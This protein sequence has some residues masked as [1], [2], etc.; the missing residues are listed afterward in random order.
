MVNHKSIQVTYL[1][2]LKKIVPPA[3]F[4]YTVQKSA[5]IISSDAKDTRS[6][7]DMQYLE[8]LIFGNISHIKKKKFDFPSFF[9]FLKTKYIF[10]LKVFSFEAISFTSLGTM[11]NVPSFPATIS[12]VMKRKGTRFVCSSIK[13]SFCVKRRKDRYQWIDN[14]FAN[15]VHI[16]L[17]T[18]GSSIF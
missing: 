16:F 14:T 2:L 13:H 18:S 4:L 3:Y 5:C 1:F 15:E 9:S 8:L 7:Y 11:Q 12:Y 17:C 10:F 6:L